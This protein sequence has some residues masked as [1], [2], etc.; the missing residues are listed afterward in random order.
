[1]TIIYIFL[2]F[3]YLHNLNNKKIMCKLEVKVIAIGREECRIWDRSL[4]S[5][6][7][8]SALIFTVMIIMLKDVGFLYVIKCVLFINTI[9]ITFHLLKQNFYFS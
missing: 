9:I 2:I 7:K 6:S 8:I 3:V 4:I 1:M 5:D